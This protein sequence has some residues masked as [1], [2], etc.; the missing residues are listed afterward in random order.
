[1]EQI[2]AFQVAAK[3]VGKGRPRFGAGRV[4]TPKAT[5]AFEKL[6]GWE[7]KLAMGKK[8][9]VTGPVAVSIRVVRKRP[10]KTKL[11]SPGGDTDNF[12]K[13]ILDA[14][15]KIVFDDD[16]QVIALTATKLWGDAD[17]ITVIVADATRKAAA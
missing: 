15:N 9:P 13:S 8:P 14:M 17:M 7:A 6:M 2:C 4:F 3:A 5:V 10:K 16:R 12:A 1:M 11:F